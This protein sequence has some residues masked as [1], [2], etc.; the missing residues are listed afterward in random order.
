MPK[1]LLYITAKIVWTFLFWGTDANE[2]R[3][4]VH[5]G[6]RGTAKLAKIWLEPTISVADKGSLTDAQIKSVMAIIS[7][8]RTELLSQWE[9]FRNGDKVKMIKIKKK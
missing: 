9:A 8:Y 7:E 3:A 4:H 5:I 1:V 2:N 6:K